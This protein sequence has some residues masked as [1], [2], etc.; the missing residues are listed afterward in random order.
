MALKR[1]LA[2]NNLA[3]NYYYVLLSIFYVRAFTN[4]RK[5]ESK[6]V[7]CTTYHK[8]DY[9]LVYLIRKQLHMYTKTTIDRNV[10]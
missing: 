10:P 5:S 2:Y 4:T 9:L 6:P 3:I 7:I 8:S 1:K